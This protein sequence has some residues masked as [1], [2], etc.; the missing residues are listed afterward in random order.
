MGVGP[1]GRPP[2]RLREERAGAL[3]GI[4]S[5]ETRNLSFAGPCLSQ[6][7]LKDQA[8]KLEQRLADAEAEKSQVHTELQD[9]QRQLSQNQ[10][11]EKLKAGS[12]LWREEKKGGKPGRG[13][14]GP[15]S[16]SLLLTPSCEKM[17][18]GI[19]KGVVTL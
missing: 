1:D 11:G 6:D 19:S 7:D 16:H 12:G 13:R 9:L 5:W 17:P 18:G 14:S 15:T 3:D 8:Q 2:Q 4:A 10:E